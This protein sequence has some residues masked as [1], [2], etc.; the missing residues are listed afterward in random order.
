MNANWLTVPFWLE[1]SYLLWRQPG[2]SLQHVAGYPHTMLPIDTNT[3]RTA[4]IPFRRYVGWHPPP[5]PGHLRWCMADPSLTG[6]VVPYIVATWFRISTRR[7]Y[8]R[9]GMPAA[10]DFGGVPCVFLY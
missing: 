1:Y 4:T 9:G 3:G 6:D 2:D 5:A 10:W 8:I 7:H